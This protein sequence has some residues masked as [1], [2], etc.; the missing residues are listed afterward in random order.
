MTGVYLKTK[1]TATKDCKS[2]SGL[3]VFTCRWGI[4]RGCFRRIWLIDCIDFCHFLQI[5]FAVWGKVCNLKAL[6]D[7]L[8]ILVCGFGVVCVVE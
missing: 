8:M 2:R 6:R 3:R 5:L 7:N 1:P 4:E